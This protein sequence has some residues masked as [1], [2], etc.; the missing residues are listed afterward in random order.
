MDGDRLMDRDIQV[1]LDVYKY[2][3]LSV[4]QI[5]SLY[6]PSFQ[7][8]RRR[9]R[10]MTADGYLDGFTAPGM[11]ESVYYVTRKGVDVV[12]SYLNVPIANL[13]WV[14]STR[15]P[16]DHYFLGHF[17]K[18]NDFRINITKACRTSNSGISLLGYIPEYYSEKTSTGGAVRYIRDFI[19]DVRDPARL[20]HHTPD[21]VFAL[22]KDGKPALFFLEIDRGTETLTDPEKGFLKCLQFYLSYWVDGK[23]QKYSD[24]FRCKPFESF[25]ALFVT[26]S[27]ER[28]DNMR[29]AAKD[30]YVDPPIVKK[31][32][33]ITT[34]DSIAGDS[35]FEPIW[36]SADIN[37]KSLYKIG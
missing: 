34:D 35:M 4:S 16:K 12:A 14:K 32:I 1:I 20:I 7:T 11:P 25:R 23:Y 6:F 33:W 30:A 18:T 36:L 31:F 13:K 22:E 2:R 3:Y 8:A 21:A 37:D 28:L 15:S 9:L 27:Q 26:T 17:L 5:A 24:D 10:A 29:K 19:C